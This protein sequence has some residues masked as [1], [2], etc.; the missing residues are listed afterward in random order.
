MKF[1]YQ[2]SVDGQPLAG[3]DSL[4]AAKQ[5]AQRCITERRKLEITAMQL[6]AAP[7]APSVPNQR[8]YYAYDG[9]VWVQK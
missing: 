1:V 6:D 2:L 7:R 5:G 3:Y 4:D 8:W 9:D